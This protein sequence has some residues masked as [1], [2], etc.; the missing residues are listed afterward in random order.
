MSQRN[1]Q[2]FA[3]IPGPLAGF[4]IACASLALLFVADGIRKA[5]NAE[6]MPTDKER[7]LSL[8][9]AHPDKRIRKDLVEAVHADELVLQLDE[10]DQRIN[11]TFSVLEMRPT[12][13]L[14]E[15]LLTASASKAGQEMAFAVLTH[16]YQHY[17]QW[18]YLPAIRDLHEAYRLGVDLSPTQCVLKIASEDEAYA[19]TCE[20]A[21]LYG[22]KT[23]IPNQCGS[24]GL[25]ARAKRF[26]SALSDLT[27]CEDVWDSLMRTDLPALKPAESAK[28][29]VPEESE[30]G[31]AQ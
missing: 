13:T 23:A 16:E 22:W 4:L 11:G 24:I 8:A 7:L 12:I 26:S 20:A 6:R 21:Y 25:S 29:S 3:A 2:S 5:R 30:Q 19:L 17:L 15:T 9:K 10:L 31:G 28:D 18:L 1:K 27:E 14:D